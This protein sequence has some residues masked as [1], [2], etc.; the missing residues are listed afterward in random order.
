VRAPAK[1]CKYVYYLG[2]RIDAAGQT[3]AVTDAEGRFSLDVQTD[4][5]FDV[6]A[7]EASTPNDN[8]GWSRVRF[9]KAVIR[10][11]PLTKA[12]TD[13]LYN[14]YEH[15]SP[16]LLWSPEDLTFI[17]EPWLTKDENGQWPRPHDLELR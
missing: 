17:S 5:W 12:Q 16:I 14:H 6:I 11:A 13:D 15:F 10:T 3:S 1:E 2:L 7:V 9:G 8:Y 4:A